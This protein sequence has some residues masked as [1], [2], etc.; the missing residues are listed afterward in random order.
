V[1]DFSLS[2]CVRREPCATGLACGMIKFKILER[3]R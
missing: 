2:A 3:Y 1:T